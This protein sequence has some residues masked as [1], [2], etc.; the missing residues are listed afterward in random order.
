[1]LQDV[2]F[3]QMLR[4]TNVLVAAHHGREAGYCEEVFQHCSPDLVL[5]SDGPSSD[6]SATEKY[7]R[8]AKGWDVLSR[9]TGNVSRRSV[10]TTRCD[11]AIVVKCS[12]SSGT[13][14]LDVSTQ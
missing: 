13:N 4:L 10:L 9:R 8:H 1:L 6:T 11:G 3:C 12:S 14:Y 2:G 5:V 7:R